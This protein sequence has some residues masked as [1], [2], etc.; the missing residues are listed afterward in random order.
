M[1]NTRSKMQTTNSKARVWLKNKGVRWI[2][3]VPHS[4]YSKDAFGVA[5]MFYIEN[6]ELKML[7]T[8]TNQWQDM[9]AIKA[10]VEETKIP[11]EV[12]MFK[13]RKE[14]PEIRVIECQDQTCS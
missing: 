12:I 3:T 6:G 9:R 8:K 5:D 11:V 7:Q 2:Y 10:F 4:R 14:E 1:I 13:D